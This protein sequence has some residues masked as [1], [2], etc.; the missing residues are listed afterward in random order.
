MLLYSED[1]RS[2][3]VFH[4]FGKLPKSIKIF[5]INLL[6][7]LNRISINRLKTPTIITFY[8][9]AKCFAKCRHCFLGS[10]LNKN[11]DKELTLPEIKKV[12]TS[13]RTRLNRIAFGGGESFLREDIVEIYRLIYNINKPSK[14]WVA[15]P[16]LYPEKIE[17][18][19]KEILLNIKNTPY[20]IAISLEGFEEVH[21]NII[22]VKGAF[23]KALRTIDLLKK[24]VERH[25]NFSLRILTTIS[26][27][28]YENLGKFIEFVDKELKLSQLFNY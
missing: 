17:K 5:C 8:V 10:R 18:I 21:D 12:F 1:Q 16:G 22:G 25:N 24:I 3:N 15:T 28:N 9:T 19:V 14:F 11:L 13:L 20:V 2:E 26:N 6:C 27:V 7:G 23:K 4:A